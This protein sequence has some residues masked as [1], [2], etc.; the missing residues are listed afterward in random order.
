M[1]QLLANTAY[2]IIIVWALAVAFW[3][4]LRVCGY[5]NI[6]LAAIFVLGGYVAYGIHATCNATANLSIVIGILSGTLVAAFTEALVIAPLRRRNASTLTQLVAALGL[7]ITI[8]NT[9][10]LSFGNEAKGFLALTRTVYSLGAVRIA[11]AQVR[12]ALWILA[13]IGGVL[14]IYVKSK[15][16]LRWRAIASNPELAHVAALG[17]DRHR[18]LVAGLAGGIVACA[19]AAVCTDLGISPTDAMDRG[20][21]GIVAALIGSGHRIRGPL[22][23][24]AIT[25]GIG[26]SAMYALGAQWAP[27]VTYAILLV[28]LCLRAAKMARATTMIGKV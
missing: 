15:T 21:L 25:S 1:Q 5:V 7:Y 23:G 3:L 13:V 26:Q 14:F 4:Q 24:A 9:V 12:V 19:G 28:V 27:S 17:A 2:D 20:L 6:A 16:G 8:V 10:A 11:A 18:I 22:L